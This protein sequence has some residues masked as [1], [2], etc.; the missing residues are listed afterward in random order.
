[1]YTDPHISETMA[2]CK[3]FP[4]RTEAITRYGLNEPSQNSGTFSS[5]SLGSALVLE[6]R[7][8]SFP[9]SHSQMR[10]NSLQG[11]FSRSPSMS[12]VPVLSHICSGST[13]HRRR[14][15]GH[16]TALY[17]HHMFA[18]KRTTLGL[19]CPRNCTTS[20]YLKGHLLGNDARSDSNKSLLG[21]GTSSESTVLGNG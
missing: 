9:T 8:S 4:W 3:S 7:P 19:Q 2:H 15:T 18:V 21:N 13:S 6:L 10:A 17:L 16:S 14:V 5:A 11:S 12:S 1:M 20:R